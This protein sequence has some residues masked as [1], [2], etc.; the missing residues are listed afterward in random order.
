[1][2]RPGF[3]GRPYSGQES[4][5]LTSITD[6]PGIGQDTDFTRLLQQHDAQIKY[7]AGNQKKLQQGV[8]EATQNPIQQLQQFIADVIVLMG[9]GQLA[10]GLLDFGDLQYILPTL[11]ALF[12]LGDGPFPLSLFE[13]AERFFLGYV[14]P[15]RQFTDVINNMIGAWMQVFGIDPKFVKDTKALLTAVGD[16]FDGL[17]GLMPSINELFG[18]LGITAAG[19]GPLGLVLKP[20][21]DL[22]SGIDLAR[23]GNAIE[24]ITDAIDP[25]IV[26]LT[27]IINFLNEV[28]RVLGAGGDVLNSPLPQLTVPFRNLMQFLGNVRL[29]VE[30]FNPILAAQQFISRLLIPAGSISNVQPNLQVDPGFDDSESLGDDGPAWTREYPDPLITDPDFVWDLIGHTADGSATVHAT[31][32][33]H[34]LQG[35]VVPVEAGQTFDLAAWVTWTGVSATGSP[36]ALQVLTDTGAITDVAAVASPGASGG[37]AQIAGSYTVPSG[38]ETIRIRLCV[39]D[40]ASAGQVWFDDATIRRTS[41]MQKGFISGLVDDLTEIFANFAAMIDGILGTGHT[42]G[43]LVTFISSG[44]STAAT[45]ADNLGAML[46]DLGLSTLNQLGSLIGNLDTGLADAATAIS[47]VGDDIAALLSGAGEATTAALGA[48][49]TQ[50]VTMLTQISDIFNGTVVT[51]VNTTVSQVQEWFNANV[52][53]LANIPNTAVQGLTGFGT[54]MGNT[55]QAL[56]DGVWQGLRAFLGIPSGVAPPQVSTAAQQVRT[57]LNNA[58]DIAATAAAFQAKQSISKQSYLSI[59]PSADPVFPLSNIN[60]ASPTTVAVTQTKSVMGVIGLPDNGLK[61][62][63]VWLGGSLTGIT[64]VYVNIYKVNTTT[65]VFTRTHRSLN[66]IGS[67][68]SPLPGYSYGWQFYNLPMTDFF[69]TLQGEWY[70]AEI[71]V[72]GTGTYNI[73]GVSNAW[74]PAHTSVYPKGLGA[75]RN[76]DTRPTVRTVGTFALGGTGGISTASTTLNVA[77]GDYIVAVTSALVFKV[78]GLQAYCNGVAMTQLGAV[79]QYGPSGGTAAYTQIWG[80]TQAAAG[81]TG[82]AVSV[83]ATCTGASANISCEAMT[84]VGVSS[85]GAASSTTGAVAAGGTMT[86]AAPVTPSNTTIVTGFTSWQAGSIDNFGGGTVRGATS[87]NNIIMGDAAGTGAAF[88]QTARNVGGSQTYNWGAVSVVLNGTVGSAPSSIAVPVYD[89]AVPW[90]S[91][92]GGAGRAQHLPETAEFETAGTF[93]YTVPSWVQD[94]DYI[95]IVPIGAGAG[96]DYWGVLAS[97]IQGGTTNPAYQ[98][99]GLAGSWNPVRLRYGDAYDI[100]TGTTSFSVTVGAPGAAAP[101]VHATHTPQHGGAGGNTTVTIPGHPTITAAGGAGSA[102]SGGSGRSPGDVVFQGVKYFGGA[103][104]TSLPAGPGLATSP[105]AG[106]A[107]GVSTHNQYENSD[108][109]STPGAP[110]ACYITAVQDS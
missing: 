46:S 108:Y 79:A 28:V 99:G 43:Q 66:I 76:S 56:T 97:P 18:A 39:K 98:Y 85:V 86:K 104:G 69:P 92:A 61:K 72:T 4:R 67:L 75:T 10:E 49:I 19:L 31:G 88:N 68:T 93:T 26:Q 94:G 59:D 53:Y 89:A 74:M 51:P 16:L 106:G 82:S 107:R 110:G 29:G 9:G 96:G 44:L 24:F 101:A 21:I 38:V 52:A 5:A 27:S 50:L 7:L 11:G 13:A 36:F 30:S 48:L 95:D 102:P 47:D 12:G 78:T 105:G 25:W 80:I 84:L 62:S 3:G 8:N 103:G 58:S 57:D 33:E 35:S 83:S 34:G 77:A 40:S 100:P 1:M 91:L 14:V 20:I 22:F 64:G 60:G 63:V 32:T 2:T 45:V 71:Q 17:A 87:S 37:W 55:V 81:T 70:V 6:S 109:N 15:T 90:I 54:N 65:G 41:L 23:F 73:V 42:F